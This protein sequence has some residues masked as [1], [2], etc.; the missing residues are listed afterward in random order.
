MT[1]FIK[2]T[3][4]PIFLIGLSVY[5]FIFI[6]NKKE[7]KD[8]FETYQREEAIDE[9][10]K[11]Q[12]V[13]LSPYFYYTSFLDDKIKLNNENNQKILNENLLKSKK[14]VNINYLIPSQNYI[15][16]QI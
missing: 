3:I 6:V 12:K 14:I 7:R 15:Q 13:P 10:K 4:I 1:E 5:F 11:Y 2:D 16:M 9:N 8:N